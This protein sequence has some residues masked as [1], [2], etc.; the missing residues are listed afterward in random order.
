MPNLAKLIKIRYFVI[1]AP[2]SRKMGEQTLK[3]IMY[4]LIAA[5]VALAGVLA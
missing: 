2:K 1:F 4:A 3:K 5:V